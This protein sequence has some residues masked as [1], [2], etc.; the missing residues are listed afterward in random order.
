MLPLTHT[1]L[2]AFSL[3]N[4]VCPFLPPFSLIPQFFNS[5]PAFEFIKHPKSYGPWREAKVDE[6]RLGTV[7][8]RT[9]GVHFGGEGLEVREELGAMFGECGVVG[10]S[11]LVLEEP[12]IGG[13]YA[14]S[15]EVHPWR[16]VSPY[17][18]FLAL[19]RQRESHT[20]PHPGFLERF[21]G[22]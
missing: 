14:G 16:V 8:I 3:L 11:G 22:K 19:S 12:V 15:Y 2:D 10:G 13:D 6:R 5:E 1:H 4:R 21:S 9:G 18:I 17:Y 7:E 20:N